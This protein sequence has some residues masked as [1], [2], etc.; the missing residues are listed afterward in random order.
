MLN[1]FVI[2]HLLQPPKIFSYG[3]VL[4]NIFW[5]THFC[6]ISQNISSFLH[7]G[8]PLQCNSSFC[9]LTYL[10]FHF[11][12]PGGG[13]WSNRCC[14]VAN[15]YSFNLSIKFEKHSNIIRNNVPTICTIH[16]LDTLY[17]HKIQC[18]GLKYVALL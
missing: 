10:I 8:G 12:P 4:S 11:H 13:L 7:S 15:M 6:L 1:I 14:S 2:D 18:R 17:S 3:V 5:K 16:H 9:D